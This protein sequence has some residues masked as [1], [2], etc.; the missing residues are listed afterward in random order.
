MFKRLLALCFITFVF[1]SNVM[2]DCEA[3]V[4]LRD[5]KDGFNSKTKA[6]DHCFDVIKN[7]WRLDTSDG[8]KSRYCHLSEYKENGYTYFAMFFQH[9][10]KSYKS[11]Y[12]QSIFYTFDSDYNYRVFDG[13]EKQVQISFAKQCKPYA[14]PY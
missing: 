6:F 2:A 12:V 1:S 8:W 13:Y 5:Y 4:F 7:V 14:D 11:R 9:Q 3:T 10:D